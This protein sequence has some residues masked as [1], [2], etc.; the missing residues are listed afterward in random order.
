MQKEELLEIVKNIKELKAEDNFI[1][2][3]S[4]HIGCPAKLYDTI[5]AFSNQN[6]G[7]KIIFGISEENGYGVV[8]VYDAKQLIEK[9][10]NVCKEMEPVV[11]GVFTEVSIDNKN[12]V[13]LEVPG[14]DALERP[15]FYRGE[16]IANGSYVRI[17]DADTKMSQ[18]EIYGYQ[19]FK[20]RIKDDK[21]LVDGVDEKNI[22]K[23]KISEYLKRIKNERPN[24][25]ANVSDEEILE[26]MGIKSEGKYTLTGV[27]IF[28]KYPQ[29]Y[30]PQLSITAVVING[31]ELGDVDDDG[32]RFIDN[33]RITGN[34]EE[35]IEQAIDFVKK[36]SKVRTVINEEGKRNDKVEYPI[37]AIREA[38]L[39][40]LVHRDYSIH[41]EGIP[42]AIQMYKD[43]IEIKNPG[44]L[45]GNIS[46]EQLGKS[47]PDT[48]NE[49]LANALEILGVTENRYSGIPT[50]NKELKNNGLDN[51]IFKSENGAFSITIYNMSC[52]KEKGN[53]KI[54]GNNIEKKLIEYLRTPKTRDEI[55]S[56]TGL[57][58]YYAINVIL[59]SMIDDGKVAL[60]LP[61]VPK[62]SKQKY[63]AVLN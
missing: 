15:V 46:V 37:K 49:I 19:A 40:A 18:T 13:S 10:K 61:N 22:D 41:T 3:K 45:Y 28:S 9:V 14:V 36:N 4:A 51:A 23:D 6:E 59:K 43:R 32:S 60:T 24:L 48:R 1:E 50:I 21:R 17:G 30:F 11:K 5:S 44:G 26:L 31:Y 33:K 56:F 2:I 63:Y 39:N 7:G 58:K 35:M 52:S 29:A 55:I 16:G 42:I 27:M 57:S 38:V 20:K 8:G 62:S 54:K 34:V 47:M 25:N 12:V 53:K